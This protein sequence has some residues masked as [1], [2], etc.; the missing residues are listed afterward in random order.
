[1]NTPKASLWISTS[2]VVLAVICSIA[3][4]AELQHLAT[5]TLLKTGKFSGIAYLAGCSY[6]LL[7]GT[8]A[9]AYLMHFV[10]RAARCTTPRAVVGA[11]FTGLRCAALGHVWSKP[12]PVLYFLGQWMPASGNETVPCAELAHMNLGSMRTCLS[13]GH[14]SLERIA[15]SNDLVSFSLEA[16]V[17]STTNEEAC[18]L[19]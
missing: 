3:L 14:T 6:S 19:H 12:T 5:V 8:V 11:A 13:C 9:G 10:P 16:S 17:P 15:D 18:S 7:A 1:M 4:F 2:A